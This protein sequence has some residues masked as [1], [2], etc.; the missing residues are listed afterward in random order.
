LKTACLNLRYSHRDRCSLFEVGLQRL[1]YRVSYGFNAGDVLISWNRIGE[2]DQA[3]EKYATV[4]VAE[5]A[6]WGNG[7]AGERWLTIAKDRHNTAGMFPVG[8]P[9]RW[10]R[11]GVELQPFRESGETV[12][13]PQ[14]GI[15]SPPVAMP[16]DWA[17]KALKKHG[18]RIRA[19]P[20][21]KPAK[22]LA[23]DLANCGRAVTWGS[24]A[25]VQAL[26]MGVKVTSEMPHWIAEQDNT[27]E[28]RLTMFQRLAWAQWR[29]EEI[30]SGEAFAR[31]L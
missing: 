1:G 25:A 27:E 7:F 24:G 17:A 5:N 18:G 6:A 31:L 28:G 11:L 8:G 15:G 16:R 23:D 21:R 14:R 26:M 10:N 13:L 3:A 22:P 29:H 9:E 19:H 12:I 4:L 30:A 2:A 20:G